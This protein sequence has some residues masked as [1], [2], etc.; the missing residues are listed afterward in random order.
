MFKIAKAE[1]GLAQILVN[2]IQYNYTIIQG[3]LGAWKHGQ[4]KYSVVVASLPNPTAVNM[5][6]KFKTVIT[7]VDTLTRAVKKF[8]LNHTHTIKINWLTANLEGGI[9]M[10]IL[11]GL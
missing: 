6:S 8:I 10:G 5:Y 11:A 4:I 9:N 7:L 1:H 2:N 3:H